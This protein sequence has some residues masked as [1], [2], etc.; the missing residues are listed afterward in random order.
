M[1]VDFGP[2]P[3]MSYWHTS[4]VWGFQPEWGVAVLGAIEAMA[5]AW[6]SIRRQPA[7]TP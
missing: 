6:R 5:G 1:R 2:L 3:L 4:A 7:R